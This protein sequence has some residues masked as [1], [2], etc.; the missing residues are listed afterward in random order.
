MDEDRLDEVQAM[1]LQRMDG[2]T[3]LD[4]RSTAALIDD[5]LAELTATE[6]LPLRERMAARK[7]LFNR[8]RRLDILS[9]LLED[10]TISEIMVNGPDHIFVE[11]DGRLERYP[12]RFRRREVLENLVQQIV[13]GVNRHINEAD[14]MV[15]ARLPDGSRVNVV[16]PPVALDG[17]VVT[18]RKF[19]QAAYSMERLVAIGSISQEAADYL[20]T[21]VRARY[22]LFI[23]GGTGSGKTTLLNSLSEY[24]APEE[25]IITI[26]DSAEL[27][28][29]ACENLVRLETRNASREGA[30]PITIRDLIRTALRMRPDRLIV[31]EVRGEEA[32]DMLQAMNTGHD[33][34]LSTGH[35]NSPG[36][37]LARLETMVLMGV[38]IPLAAV[39][40]QIAGALDILV[41]VGRLR[42]GSRR[43]VSVMEV[44]PVNEQG[45]IPLATLFQF[46]EE[47]ERHGR[48]QG[49]LVYTG[50]RL[51]QREKLYRAGSRLALEPEATRPLPGAGG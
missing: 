16:L 8:F 9:D 17:P 47:G 24:I 46:Q 30:A 12:G 41:Q 25:R 44:L 14:P 34:S 11:R 5:C 3:Q 35:A 48:I 37:M 15:D 23:C 6:A 36:D 21:L 39:R 38:E 50:E 4:D 42:D 20:R 33:G 7:A 49:R 1:V 26:E 28:I 27:Q 45:Q 31:G 43:V 32:I 19:S 29:T 10:A 18:I 22:N 40:A 13:A 2:L 51:R